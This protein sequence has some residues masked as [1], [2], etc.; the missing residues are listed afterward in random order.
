MIR[1]T[2]LGIRFV[3][4]SRRAMVRSALRPLVPRRRDPADT[5]DRAGSSRFWALRHVDLEVPAGTCLGVCGANGAGKTTL[6]RLMAGILEPDEGAVRVAGRT[7]A[8]LSVGA[9]ISHHLTGAENARLAGTLHG[10]DRRAIDALYPAIQEFA[11]L[12]D[13]TMGT[14]VRYYSSGMRTRLGFAI[15]SVLEPD[16]L[17]LDEILS[18]GD[19]AFRE[20]SSRRIR[21]LIAGAR[22]VV[23][24][25]H[26]VGFL[27]AQCDRGVWLD[28]GRVMAA[29]AGAEVFDAYARSAG[30]G[31]ARG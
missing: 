29:G 22:C 5:A 7:S 19:Q 12:D 10:L 24:C 23:L 2:D 26:N 30:G 9:G 28:L 16:V 6:M 1:C 13:A 18:G 17:L 3:R 15:V 8:L 20:R 11:G 21:E 25:S 4:G 27:K 31:A 14:P